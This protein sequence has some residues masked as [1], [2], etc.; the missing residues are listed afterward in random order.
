MNGTE[1]ENFIVIYFKKEC[2]N[3]RLGTGYYAKHKSV[4]N[5]S[6]IPKGTL[7]ARILSTSFLNLMSK[8]K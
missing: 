5:S 4:K 6:V 3:K 7:K 1:I 8:N 2:R